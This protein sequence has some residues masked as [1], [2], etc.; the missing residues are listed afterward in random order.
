MMTVPPFAALTPSA[1][2]G[3][4][5]NID[6]DRKPNAAMLSHAKAMT[7]LRV[8]SILSAFCAAL[9]FVSDA[10]ACV[11]LDNR[12]GRMFNKC[13]YKVLVDFKTVGGGCYAGQHGQ[14]TIDTGSWAGTGLQMSCSNSTRW[15]NVWAWCRYDDWVKGTCKPYAK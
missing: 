15:T 9:L 4:W 7:N 3:A 2:P 11:Q 8:L 13:G 6:A 5:A 1:G 14:V 12:T 10:A